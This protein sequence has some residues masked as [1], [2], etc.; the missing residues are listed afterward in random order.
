MRHLNPSIKAGTSLLLSLFIAFQSNLELN[1]LLGTLTF[2][3]VLWYLS[4][5]R[6]LLIFLWVFLSMA[7]VFFTGYFYQSGTHMNQWLYAVNVASRVY[8]FAGLGLV[9]SVTTELKDFVYSLEQQ[10]H[11]P[12]QFSYGILAAF[13][14]LP[15]I[16]N[17]LE[18][19]RKSCYSRGIHIS[20]FSVNLLFPL[21]VKSI[22]WSEN[23]AYAMESKGFDSTVKRTQTKKMTVRWFDYTYLFLGITIAVFMTIIHY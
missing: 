19:I 6:F 10:L 23:L 3:S 13:H 5:Q 21:L 12:T 18:N 17:E 22:R 7:G 1:L 14:M 15:L 16:P 9:F 8:G 20:M 11:L 4:F 2:L